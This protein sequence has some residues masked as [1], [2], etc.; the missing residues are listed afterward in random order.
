MQLEANNNVMP[1]VI[2]HEGA[3]TG[4]FNFINKNLAKWKIYFGIPAKLYSYR[5]K[6]LLKYI[7]KQ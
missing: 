6:W 3:V 5:S 2:L 1:N 7:E 4:L